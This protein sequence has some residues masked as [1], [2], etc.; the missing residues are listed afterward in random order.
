M[1]FA[2]VSYVMQYRHGQ[3]NA[4]PDTFT[5]TYCSAITMTSST[6][7]YIHDYVVLP[8]VTRLLHFVCSNKLPFSTTDVK[9]IISACKICA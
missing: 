4:G 5:K 8:G 3:R 6:L 9:R 1:E 7:Q 2:P